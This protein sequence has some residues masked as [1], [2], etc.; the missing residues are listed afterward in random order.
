MPTSL[1]RLAARRPWRGAVLIFLILALSLAV[2]YKRYHAA[3][4]R[5]A[6]GGPRFP[7]LVQAATRI[8]PGIYLLGGLLPSVAYV[9]DTSDG[10]V[11]IDSGL[12][13]DAARV[14][15]QM[16]ELGLDWKRLRAIFL[17]HAH[18]DHSGG[19]EALRAAT[20]ARI[21]AGRGDVA[22]LQKGEPREAF[23]STFYMP[24]YQQRP[25]TVDV[26]LDGGER[27]TIGE[28]RIEAIA[29]PG[30]TPGSLCYLVEHA[31]LHALFAGD[32][33]MSL[34]GRA[35]PR[36]ELEKPLGTYS[37]Y[38][39]PRYRGDA[40]QSLDSLRRLRDL[41]V[42]DLVLP[43]H[44]AADHPPESPQLTQERW[45]SLLDQGIR[46]METLVARYEADGANFL[47]GVPKRLLPDLYYLGDFDGS[48]V[49]AFF[50]AAKLYLVDAA[51]ASGIV[52]FVTSSLNKLGRGPVVPP[53]AVLLTSCGPKQTAGIEELVEK[54]HV[55]VIVSSAGI[56]AIKKL[57]SSE[58][59]IEPA[60]VLSS[61]RD[62][63]S[64][65][66]IALK[67][68]GIAPMAYQVTLNGKVVLFSGQIPVELN[69]A[70]RLELMAEL[71]VSSDAL[72]EYFAALTQLLRINPS[73]WLPSKPTDGQNAN[74]YDDHWQRTIEDNLQVLNYMRTDQQERH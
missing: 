10:L 67:G 64:I 37:A 8:A 29:T 52:E 22:V 69:R 21:H 73:L 31:G 25:I 20:G 56:D 4:Q 65:T 2:G 54:W 33:I 28:T 66:A 14:K 50:V 49:F 13:G 35:N 47:D 5:F 59:T 6:L 40:R 1:K 70:Q 17:T 12:E 72:H 55:R 61:Q 11:L 16:T 43:G 53:T 19:A 63:P 48:A 18:G 30:H 9:V 42:P 15:A 62:L 34:R 44:P 46:D 51:G 24:G 74:L 23:F 68:R 45:Q 27:L 39:A 36:H 57:Y 32:V 3:G 58:T 41:P 26:A 38:L 71:K 60:D 7:H